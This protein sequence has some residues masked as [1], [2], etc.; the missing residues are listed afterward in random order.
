[1][2]RNMLAVLAVV[3]L[4]GSAQAYHNCG[5]PGAKCERDPQLLPLP[6]TMK[7]DFQFELR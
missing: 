6:V 5:K 4:M 1:M 7:E 2:V 3:A